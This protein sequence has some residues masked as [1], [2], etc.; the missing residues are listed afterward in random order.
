MSPAAA[1]WFAALSAGDITTLSTLLAPEAE[2]IGP[3][4]R[5]VRGSAPVIRWLMDAA[6]PAD[7]RLHV[8]TVTHAHGIAA[9]TLCVEI[10]LS[11][12]QHRTER[13][14]MAVTVGR[15]GVRRVVIDD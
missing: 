14:V 2:L 3:D 5:R 13:G 7:A 4:G 10:L 12:G 15:R 6:S 1:G 8:G 11:G 9:A